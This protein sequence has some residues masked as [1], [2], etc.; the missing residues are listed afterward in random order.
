MQN[1]N[2]TNGS[3]AAAPGSQVIQ[4]NPVQAA[5]FAL[6]FL[7]RAPHT[8]GEREAYDVATMF[9]QAICNGQVQ[10]VANPQPQVQLPGESAPG[11]AVQ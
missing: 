1:G 6:Q 11:A 7:P 2:G 3:P 8:H 4:V 9:L 10:L 5:A